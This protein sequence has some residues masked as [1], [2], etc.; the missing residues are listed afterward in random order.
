MKTTIIKWITYILIYVFLVSMVVYM[1]Y[2]YN[3]DSP[4]APWLS[5]TVTG[6]MICAITVGAVIGVKVSNSIRKK[7]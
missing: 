1:S 5:F 4:V 7:K 2:T 6:L 3:Q